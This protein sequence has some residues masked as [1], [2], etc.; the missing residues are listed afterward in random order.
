M[1]GT[2]HESSKSSKKASTT[3]K[4]TS[5]QGM[6]SPSGASSND[7][8]QKKE[9]TVADRTSRNPEV[10]RGSDPAGGEDNENRIP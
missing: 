3:Q 2:K 10:P 8:R 1:R 9:P 6:Q 7:W 4:H 5:R